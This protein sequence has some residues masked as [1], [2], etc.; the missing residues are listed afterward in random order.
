MR[1]LLVCCLSALALVTVGCSA[2]N[3][4]P[5]STADGMI[6]QVTRS[7]GSF[8]V[9]WT[10]SV[11]DDGSAVVYFMSRFEFHGDG[12]PPA[13]IALVYRDGTYDLI[14]ELGE[15][16]FAG[17]WPRFS[18]IS[19]TIVA[20][21]ADNG[22][23]GSV[24][25]FWD[26]DSKVVSDGPT[27]VTEGEVA[28]MP[29]R[30]G[31]LDFELIG[32]VLYWTQWNPD[33]TEMRELLVAA[34]GD[35]RAWLPINADRSWFRLGKDACASTSGQE[36]LWAEEQIFGEYASTFSFWEIDV[37]DPHHP[38]VLDD[39][40]W[41]TNR[42]IGW[43]QY[44]TSTRCGDDVLS[45]SRPENL[46]LGEYESAWVIVDGSDPAQVR[47]LNGGIPGSA[48]VEVGMTPEWI[49]LSGALLM[50]EHGRIIHRPSGTFVEIPTEG[51]CT[52][53]E[54]HGDFVSWQ[55]PARISVPALAPLA[56]GC[57]TYVGVLTP[58]AE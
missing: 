39:S 56:A 52:S 12:T 17:E 46:N 44:V 47:F 49:A 2:I 21:V 27:T 8:A 36:F 7:D 3:Q 18:A 19:D 40:E 5:T 29:L 11:G 32:D 30:P 54:I 43:F 23:D 38:V 48:S 10:S 58:P 9:A 57:D 34:T 14:A 55:V 41:T 37:T 50:E 31:G 26:R 53:L 1:A 35:G 16:R 25:H 13:G 45:L 33:S 51:V 20:W 15:P 6:T 24:I 28:G 42:T 4:F 22:D